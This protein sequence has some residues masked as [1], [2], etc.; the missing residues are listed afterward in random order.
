MKVFIL[1]RNRPLFLW[2]C[3]DSLYRLTQTQCEFI[4]IDSASDDPL[5]RP[6]IDGFERR[7][8]FSEIIWLKRNEAL[9]VRAAIAERLSAADEYFAFVESDAVLLGG[10]YSCWLSRMRDLMD[11]DPMLAMLGSFDDMADLVSMEVARQIVPDATDEELLILTHNKYYRPDL[12][13]KVDM[14]K[15]VV[16]PHNPSGRLLMLRTPIVL[17]VGGSSDSDLHDRLIQLGYKTGISTQV[18]HR[19]LSLLNIFDYPSYDTS[20]R[21]RFMYGYT[22]RSQVEQNIATGA[23]KVVYDP[24]VHVLAGGVRVEG[25][26]GEGG[27]LRFDLPASVEEPVLISRT[28]FALDTE[29]VRPLGVSLGSLIIDGVERLFDPDLQRGWYPAES[30]W[31]WTAGRAELPPARTIELTVVGSVSYQTD[32]MERAQDLPSQATN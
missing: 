3:L 27:V 5:V 24:D 23:V 8:M 11:A 16:S 31:R 12:Y 19:H 1:S 10:A 17:S 14:T 9:L 7:K 6:V 30:G 22:Y 18:R 2:S 20:K 21:R 15:P 4:I 28:G 26:L 29:D 25:V 32:P 13:D